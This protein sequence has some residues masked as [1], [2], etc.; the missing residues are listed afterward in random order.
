MKKIIASYKKHTLEF[1]EPANTSKGSISQKD[2]FIIKIADKENPKIFGLGES[3]PLSKLSPDFSESIEE[4]VSHYCDLINEE[5]NVTF[6]KELIDFPSIQFALESAL[7]ELENGGNHKL[8][9]TDFVKGK[10][11]I[12]INALIWMSDKENMLKQIKERLA[13]GFKSIKIKIGSI[14]F[15]DET[16][17][18]EQ[19]RK[20][21]SASD[22]EIRLDANG[23]FAPKT[24]LS[25]LE[26][27]A[28]F[29]IHSI[30]QPIQQGKWQEM[31]NLCSKTP[32]P[33][34]LDEELVGI[35]TKYGRK[36]MLE[37]I[38]PQYIV[39]KPTLLGGFISCQ[40]LIEISEEF[41][42]S[43]WISSMLESNVGLNA[44]SQWVSTFETNEMFQGLATSELYTNNIASPLEIK[45]GEL[46]Y[47]NKLNWDLSVLGW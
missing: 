36:I 37:I 30:E 12:P 1:K 15:D 6:D 21:Y 35:K 16:Y 2:S 33:I 23:A 34:A 43:W 17:L 13:D 25:Y 5:E 8:F 11:G 27:L 4:K 45:N 14:N 7:L 38:K 46:L 18:L 31:A 28:K 29:N 47:N 19:I 9:D 26:K 42:I 20:E 3:S 41:K 40:E 39:L 44:I 32:V 10:K 22:I 24:A